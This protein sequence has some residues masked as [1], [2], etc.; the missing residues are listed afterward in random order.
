[1]VLSFFDWILEKLILSCLLLVLHV[2][3]IVAYRNTKRK[4]LVPAIVSVV[5]KENTGFHAITE[6]GGYLA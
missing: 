2:T 5:L 4:V 6:C 1:M 3:C